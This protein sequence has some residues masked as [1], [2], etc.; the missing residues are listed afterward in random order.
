MVLAA[1]VAFLTVG[2]SLGLASF[3]GSELTAGKAGPSLA[4]LLAAASL[5]A[6]T[7][8]TLVA[9]LMAGAEATIDNF[10]PATVVGVVIGGLQSIFLFIPVTGPAIAIPWLFL[11]AAHPRVASHLLRS[12]GR[13]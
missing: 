10:A 8:G 12:G 1:S 9:I 5:V 4:R 3:T 11:P 13:R 2:V 7:L 6:G